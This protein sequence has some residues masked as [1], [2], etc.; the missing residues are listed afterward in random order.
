MRK[1]YFITLITVNLAINAQIQIVNNNLE[2]ISGVL[3]IQSSKIISISDQS[4]IINI[5]TSSRELDNLFLSHK[6][7]YQKELTPEILQS[8]TTIILTKKI[9]TFDPIVVSGGRNIRYKKDIALLSQRID[10]KKIELFLPQTSADLLNVDLKIYFQ[11]RDLVGGSR[12]I[13]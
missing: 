9:N 11:K 2:H 4:G 6:N 8:N 12:I 3:L 10:K 5:D 1:L 13:R 7:Y